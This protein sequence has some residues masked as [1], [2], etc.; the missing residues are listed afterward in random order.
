MVRAIDASSRVWIVRMQRDLAGNDGW[1]IVFDRL[2]LTASRPAP[3]QSAPLG[4]TTPARKHIAGSQNRQLLLL[5]A[6]CGPHDS[7]DRRCS[8]NRGGRFVLA[9]DDV[10]L[11]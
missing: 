3:W 8:K 2:W 9:D 5:S 1:A 6:H 11:A 4:E 7:S 10:T